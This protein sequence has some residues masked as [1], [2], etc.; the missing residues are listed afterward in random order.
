MLVSL[1]ILG[2]MSTMLLGGLRTVGAF[3]GRTDAQSQSLDQVIT[4]QRLIRGRVEHLRALI[5]PNSSVPL[6]DANG[7]AGQFTFI[8]PPLARSE[9]DSLWRY[10]IMVT[11]SGDFLLY[12]ANSL[13]DRYNFGE[14]D[15]RGWQPLTLLRDVDSVRID[16]FGARL[17][18][19]GRGWQDSW[20]L[21]PQAPDLVR[22]R[23]TFRNG[24][25]R[26][27]PDL[28][29]QPRATENAACR[30]DVLSGRCGAPT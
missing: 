24:D 13:D 5:N 1:A 16:Y 2:M 12:S 20:I 26:I 6:V 27:W 15:T 21:R 14:R 8:A 18:Q 23:V 9:P 29:V 4:A 30:I 17:R 22:I 11:A 7:D 10:R 25:R 3:A 19:P 28:I